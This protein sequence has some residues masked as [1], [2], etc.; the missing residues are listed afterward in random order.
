[1]NGTYVLKWYITMAFFC[2]STISTR[3]YKIF[4]IMSPI[5][6]V[7]DSLDKF[8][9]HES[10]FNVGIFLFLCSESKPEGGFR[11]RKFTNKTTLKR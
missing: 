11:T 8:L 3:N 1:M 7:F 6:V 9:E 5:H 4:F 2:N 10:C